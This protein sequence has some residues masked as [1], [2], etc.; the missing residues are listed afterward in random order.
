M[1]VQIVGPQKFT[2]EQLV[3]LR[4][5]VGEPEFAK[6]WDA[7]LVVNGEVSASTPFWRGNSGGSPS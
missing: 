3:K 4:K 1:A 2:V 6:L 7:C 5:A